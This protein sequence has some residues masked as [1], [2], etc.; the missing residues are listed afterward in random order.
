M[1][2]DVSPWYFERFTSLRGQNDHS[3]FKAQG[4]WCTWCHFRR[5]V[6]YTS[7]SRTGSPTACEND[8][9]VSNGN[10]PSRIQHARPIISLHRW[11]KPL[12]VARGCSKT[13]FGASTRVIHWDETLTITFPEVSYPATRSPRA[14]VRFF[15]DVLA[16]RSN[17]RLCRFYLIY[18]K[19]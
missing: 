6:L 12:K 13:N 4:P 16:T 11:C 3:E 7:W 8:L 10:S 19:W 2:I 18:M 15:L 5:N 9:Y 14:F 1:R 17:Q